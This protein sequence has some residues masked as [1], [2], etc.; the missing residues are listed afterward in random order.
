MPT[1]DQNHGLTPLEKSL[2]SSSST[3]WFYC[4][5]RLFFFLVYLE[6]HLPGVFCLKEKKWKNC[7]FLTKTMVYPLWKNQNFSTFFNLLFLYSRKAFFLSR[8]ERLT[9]LGKF[10]SSTFSTCWFYRLE[11]L[12]FFLEYPETHFAGVYCLK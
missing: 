10:L 5:E 9:P 7:Q 8:I 11:R 1:F 4:P 6:T 2:S 12:F 3:C